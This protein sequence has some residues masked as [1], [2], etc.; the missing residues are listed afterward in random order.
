MAV[1]AA[2]VVE[3]AGLLVLHQHHRHAVVDQRLD[4]DGQ[5]LVAARLAHQLGQLFAVKR[6][7]VL[8]AG[9][10]VQLG[11]NAA[12]AEFALRVGAV[13][14]VGDEVHVDGLIEHRHVDAALG[15]QADRRILPRRV[16]GVD[17]LIRQLLAVALLVFRQRQEFA[18]R[19]LEEQAV[20][21]AFGEFLI[22]HHAILDERMDIRPEA[23]VGFAL[24]LEHAGQAVG[25]LLGDVVGDAAH[26]AVVLQEGAGDVQRE[27]RAVDHALEQH[28]EFRNDLFDVVGDEHLAG[29]QLDLAFD[30]A[31]LLLDLREIQNTLE[32]ERIIHVQ[33]NP[34]QRIF[35]LVEHLAVELLIILVRAI[36]R[37]AG[38]ERLGVV[39]GL[40]RFLLGLGLFLGALARHLGLFLLDF[41]KVDRHGHERAIAVEH[42]AHA[43][44]FEEFALRLAD[45][46]GDGRAARGARALGHG[47]GHAVLALPANRGRALAEG[48]RVDGHLIGDHEHGIEAQA[49]VAD[50]AGIFLILVLG[51]FLHEGFRAGERDLIDVGLD[52][53]LGHAHAVVDEAELA[54]GLIHLHVD[55]AA[56][57]GGAVH[58]AQLGDRVAAVGNDLADEDVFIGIQPFLD[59]RHDI[60]SVDG[61]VALNRFHNEKPPYTNGVNRLIPSLIRYASVLYRGFRAMSREN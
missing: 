17:H 3:A 30:A 52:L 27:I 31:E 33:V 8:G 44:D 21:H 48:E 58:H 59:D 46:Q 56:L 23:L 57:R 45:V 60:L 4:L 28:Q 19:R 47:E 32:L 5:I 53:V 6:R 41:V 38:V 2:H 20:L 35:V 22:A 34:E 13:F 24:G 61:Y 42:L 29:I 26:I 54:R 10:A 36:L 51:V 40:R 18:V 16:G 49:E 15:E 37:R 9:Q 14:H 7:G 43:P 1:N 39:D 11:V 50:D 55:G 25:D 12:V